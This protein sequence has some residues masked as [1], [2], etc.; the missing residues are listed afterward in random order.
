MLSIHA[1]DPEG[2]PLTF[3]EGNCCPDPILSR[4]QSDIS[5]ILVGV[6]T[7]APK[8]L[9]QKQP[10]VDDGTTPCFTVWMTAA[11]SSCRLVDI[12]SQH[13]WSCFILSKI[14]FFMAW[15]LGDL[16][17]PFFISWFQKKQLRLQAS[18]HEFDSSSSSWKIQKRVFDKL[19]HPFINKSK[20][21]KRS[22]RWLSS[23]EHLFLLRMQVQVLALIWRLIPFSTPIPVLFWTL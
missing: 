4:N 19:Q 1:R 21:Y 22:Y 17:N 7:A 2:A 23:R 9:H 11:V 15:M 3:I 14:Q 6:S 18:K 13:T 5:T 12:P 20:R 16:F 8:H 10:S